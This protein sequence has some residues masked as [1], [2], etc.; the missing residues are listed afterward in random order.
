MSAAG[1]V[2]TGLRSRRS[3][4]SA[5]RRPSGSAGRSSASKPVI[6]AA[7]G[8][9]LAG[10][11][12]GCGSTA[13]STPQA[14]TASP[15]AP[16]LALK[17][18]GKAGEPLPPAHFDPAALPAFYYFTEDGRV[19]VWSGPIGRPDLA[20]PLVVPISESDGAYGTATRFPDG[21]VIVPFESRLDDSSKL[22]LLRPGEDPRMLLDRVGATVGGASEAGSLVVWRRTRFDDDGVWQVWLDGRDP[23]IVLPAVLRPAEAM[24]FGLALSPDGT[25][26]AAAACNG[27]MQVRWPGQEPARIQL[28]IPLGFTRGGDLIA[29]GDCARFRIVRFKPGDSTGADLVPPESGYQAIVTPDGRHL[30]ARHPVAFPGTLA[31]IDL[32][33]GERRTSV[34]SEGG[35]DFTPDTTDR[36]VVMRRDDGA[37]QAYRFTWAVHDLL[38]GWTGYFV[39]DTYPPAP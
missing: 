31:V 26:V 22:L 8:L 29:Y 11:I 17:A 19:G 28:G 25:S 38:E 33:S 30:A 2:R 34:L 21:S 7:I 13:P 24:R 16:R 12:A 6:R 37:G 23:A 35:W 10:S 32:E 3:A 1:A 27:P 5:T 4:G 39:V 20:T 15:A 14:P 9:L 36:F 18:T